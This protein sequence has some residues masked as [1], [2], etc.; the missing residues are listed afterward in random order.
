[1]ACEVPIALKDYYYITWLVYFMNA[2]ICELEENPV[3]RDMY[4]EILSEN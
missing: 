3:F 1:M 2:T 4:A